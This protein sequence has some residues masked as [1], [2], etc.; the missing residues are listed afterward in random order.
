L[1]NTEISKQNCQ[2]RKLAKKIAKNGNW[3]NKL[4]KTETGKINCQSPIL[5]RKIANNQKL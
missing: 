5:A 1:P 2:K 3:Q 4:P